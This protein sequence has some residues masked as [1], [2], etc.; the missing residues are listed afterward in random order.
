M[1][2]VIPGLLL[3]AGAWVQ[4]TPCTRAFPQPSGQLPSDLLCFSNFFSTDDS[5]IVWAVD[6][7][8]FFLSD[9]EL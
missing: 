1:M 3:L 5:V 6:F 8:L 7:H 9:D 4:D 2:S